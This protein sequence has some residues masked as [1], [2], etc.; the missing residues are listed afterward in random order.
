MY[1]IYIMTSRT[2][3]V[4]YIGVTN[5]IERRVY[6]H[7]NHLVEGFT[8]KY[9]I[10]KLVYYEGTNNIKEAL[11]REKQL[12]KWSRKKKEKLIKTLNKEWNDLSLDWY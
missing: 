8:E 3:E 5:N 1:Y 6:E 7:K 12:K 9:D 11:A 10:E 4:L 2:F